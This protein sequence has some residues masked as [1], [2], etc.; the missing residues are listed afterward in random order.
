MRESRPM[1]PA[2]GD[3]ALRARPPKP[4]HTGI[5]VLI[6]R[7]PD[8]GGWMG[9]RGAEEL[10]DV[11]ADFIDFA[12]IYAAHS[13]MLPERWIREHVAI[14]QRHGIPVYPGGILMEIAYLQGRMKNFYAGV[15][16]LGFQI[17]EISENYLTL[18]HDDRLR[19]IGEAK[20]HGVGV[21]FEVGSKQPDRPLG[22]QQ[23]VDTIAPLVAAGVEHI[24]L[25]QAEIDQWMAHAPQSLRAVSEAVGPSHL[26]WEID[27]TRF[28]V[29]PIAL[30]NA[31]GVEAN[32]GNVHPDQII[33]VEEFRRGLGRAI[34][35]PFVASGARTNEEPGA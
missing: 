1:S 27:P 29:H 26:I 34:G 14:Y 6:D 32:L 7:G 17:V 19:L 22:V 12:K 2:F 23:A 9:H 3:L 11:A 15:K 18:T 20:D 10:L 30:L 21:I 13:L 33:R 8:V 35:F 16:N 4:R 25:E 24:V 28:P 31:L 5:T